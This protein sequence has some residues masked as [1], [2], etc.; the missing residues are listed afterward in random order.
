MP[1]NNWKNL[2]RKVASDLGVQRVLQ[3]GL[4]APDVIYKN[5]IIECKNRKYLNVEEAIEQLESYRENPE[6][7]LVLIFKKNNKRNT[8]VFMK[9]KDFNIFLKNSL[10]KSNCLVQI[11]Y[12]DFI[13]YAKK[14]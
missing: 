1:N 6:Q 5:I 10:H 7:I 11:K 12:K 8:D 4:S 2:E 14:T 9:L 3:K 13:E